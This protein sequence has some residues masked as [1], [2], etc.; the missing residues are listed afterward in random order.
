MDTGSKRRLP[1]WMGRSVSMAES[2]SSD[3]DNV[4]GKRRMFSDKFKTILDNSSL[5]NSRRIQRNGGS[6]NSKRKCDKTKKKVKMLSQ[7]MIKEEDELTIEDLISLAE[8]CLGGNKETQPEPP[9]ASKPEPISNPMASSVSSTARGG[10]LNGASGS[11]QV[12]TK[13]AQEKILAGDPAQEMLDLLLGPLLKKASKKESEQETTIEL[14]TSGRPAPRAAPRAAPLRN[15]LNQKEAC[16]DPNSVNHAP[17]PAPVQGGGGSI[18]GGI[19]STIAQGMAFGTGSAVAHRAVDSV[20][21]PRTV[22]HETVVSQVPEAASAPAV[23]DA[24]SIHSKA[25]LDCINNYGSDI[26]KCQFYLDMLTECR[27]GSSGLG[28]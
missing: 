20:L 25:F 19:G 2:I 23:E 28:A 17:P 8:E 4:L 14:F 6:N 18:L 7:E 16:N 9:V 22:Q 10:K 5:E 1:S 3:A 27:R 26:G 21:G 15:P 13:C 12:L 24:C 11:L